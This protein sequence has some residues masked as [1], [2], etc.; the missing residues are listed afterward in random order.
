M[1]KFSTKKRKSVKYYLAQLTLPHFPHSQSSALNKPRLFSAAA[2]PISV[3]NFFFELS[4][5]TRSLLHRLHWLRLAKFKFLQLNSL[6]G[7]LIEAKKWI[8][9]NQKTI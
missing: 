4:T 7:T 6:A 5:K 9:F 8:F 1:N 2:F 3:P